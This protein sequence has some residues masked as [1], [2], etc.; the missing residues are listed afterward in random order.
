VFG[1][2]VNLFKLFGFQVRIDMSW[3]VI[4]VLVAWSLSS[5]FFPVHFENLST[6]AYWIMGI[7]G[8]VGLF[9]SIIFHEM[10]HSLVA[11]RFGLPMR[12]ITLFIFGGVAEMDQEPPSPKA[13]FYMAVIGPVSSFV[14][15]GLFY[16]GYVAGM[17][18]R[19]PAMA[20]GILMYLAAI[21]GILGLFNLV[22]AFPLDGGRILRSILWKAKGNLRW[23]TKVSSWIGSGFGILLIVLGVYSFLTGNF[24]GG[25]WWFL[26]GLFLRNAAS[27]SYQQLLIRRALEGEK[28]QRFM[29]EDPVTVPPSL[30]IEDLVEHYIYKYHYKM[31]PVVEG[32]KLVG[33]MTTKQVKEVPR[34]QW[35]LKRVGDLLSTC[36]PENTIA[37]GVDAVKALS[38]MSR[39]RVSRLMVTVDN[40]LVGVISLKDML[41]FIAHKVELED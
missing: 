32:G 36:S 34:E 30:S 37:P 8:A 9:L 33:C 38:A 27:M 35:G 7:I 5:G 4:A 29:T 15:A 19:W 23:G 28:V 13:E 25:L 26:I 20:T 22:P 10:A 18:Q 16:W 41:S 3:I 31:F 2:R 21:N 12:G 6:Q 1:R 40:R 11:R 39:N 24:I 14:L 17:Q